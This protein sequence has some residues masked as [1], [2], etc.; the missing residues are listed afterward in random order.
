M[1]CSEGSDSQVVAGIAAAGGSQVLDVHSDPHH[2]RSVLTMASRDSSA[3]L[4]AVKQVVKAAVA[5]IDLREHVGV[6]PY[7][8]SADVVPF[9]PL[10]GSS[11]LEEA[12]EAR[13][14][15]ARW[16]AEELGVP[17]FLYGPERTLPDI[18][19]EGFRSIAPDCGPTKPHETAGATCVGARMPLVAYNIWLA[20][21]DLGLATEL[22]RELRGPSVRALGLDLGGHVQVSC[23]LTDPKEVGPKMVYDFV[24]AR[25]KIERAE[26]VGLIPSYVLKEV[27]ASRW[28][29][30]D[31]D[32]SRTIEARL[33]S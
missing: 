31:L 26:L 14:A 32:L 20:G 1:N 19:R 16:I 18:R 30:L 8:G 12:L 23:N 28:S 2:N 21:G 13:N 4:D 11:S 15:T 33:T 7:M 17:C 25:A 10:E 5:A 3:L 24:A 9:A 22:A 27:P 6:H 29:E